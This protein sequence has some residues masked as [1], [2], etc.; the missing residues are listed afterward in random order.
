[1]APAHSTPTTLETDTFRSRKMP[2]G[3]SGDR[4]RDSI[5][6]KTTSSTPAAA[7]RPSVRAVVQPTSLPFTIA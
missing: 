5:T 3:T 2:S 1:M 4:T 7:S 6:R